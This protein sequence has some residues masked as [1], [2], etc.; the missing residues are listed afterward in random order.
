MEEEQIKRKRGRPATGRKPSLHKQFSVMLPL[1]LGE[2]GKT[3]PGG[4]SGQLRERLEEKK[5]ETEDLGATE[6][7]GVGDR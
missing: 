4:L 6:A 2:W 5:R 3:L 1:E 7:G